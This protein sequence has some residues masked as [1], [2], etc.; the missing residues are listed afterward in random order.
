[1]AAEGRPVGAR[2]RDEPPPNSTS[3]VNFQRVVNGIPGFVCTLTPAGEI[4][5]VNDQVLGY[6][7]RTLD[8]LRDWAVSDAVHPDDLLNVIDTLRVSIG[9]GQPSDVELRL[10][11]ADGVYRWFLLQRRP[12]RDSHGQIVRWYTLHTDIDQRKRAEDALRTNAEDLRLTLDGIDGLVTT[13]SPSGQLE[14][15]NR[16][17]QEYTERTVEQLRSDREI[18]H[19]DD[20][21]KVMAQWQR[22]L[23]TR[24]PLYA[25]ARIRRHDG[26]FR[27]FYLTALPVHVSTGEIARWY[28]LITDIEERRQTEDRLRR[29]EADLLEAQRLTHTGSWKLDVSS[30]RV[31]VSPE[32]HRIFETRAGEDPSAVAFWFGR[33]H[34][35]DRSRVQTLFERCVAER[36]DYQTDYRIVCPDGTIKFQH[37]I[38][39]P[40]VNAAGELIEFAGTA[41]DVTDQVRSR[42]ALENAFAENKKLKEQL[43]QENLALRDEVD[44]ASMFEEI[45]GTSSALQSVISRVVKV[46]PTDSTVL[47]TGETGTGKEL[48]A[49]AIHRRSHRAHRPFVSVNCSALPASLISSELFGHEKGAFTGAAQRRVGRFELAHGGTI[50]L[51]EVGELPGDTQVAL[52]RVL[53]ER[54]FERVGGQESIRVDVRVIA[55]TNRHLGSAQA[56]GA[57]RADLFYRLNVFPI[58]VPPLRERR[59]DILMLLEYFSSG[60]AK[61]WAS[62]SAALTSARSIYFRATTGRAISANCRMS[63]SAQSSSLP[64]MCFGSIQ[65]GCRRTRLVPRT[66]LLL[67]M[68]PSRRLMSDR[69]SNVRSK[70][71]AAACQ[72][73]RALRRYFGYLPQ[74]SIRRSRSSVSRKNTSN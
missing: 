15:A 69:S 68:V 51:D 41:M 13:F 30:G 57:F 43:Y 35:D 61:S 37:S 62:G 26:V 25:E 12:H 72:G 21:A 1:M 20:R 36:C 47:I 71:P 28:S 74:H 6:F 67:R 73:Q 70:S 3:D 42:A 60:S 46:A 52:L 38:G 55:A 7:G 56:N 49:R 5:F 4:E 32:I 29:S 48:I 45:V 39:Y 2:G 11:R 66:G 33:I 16:R 54:E 65:R 8:D 10:R 14:F 50:F 31:T 63:L 40:V 17:F 27:W 9:S 34:P 19:P 53:Q 64:A 44:R 24:E 18:L 22:A 23:E 59:D 58:D